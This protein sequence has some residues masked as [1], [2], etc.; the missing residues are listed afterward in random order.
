MFAYLR[1]ISRFD[2]DL[3]IDNGDGKPITEEQNEQ[4]KEVREAVQDEL[5]PLHNDRF[6]TRYL[7]AMNFNVAKA[8]EMV[9]NHLQWRKDMEAERPIDELLD[10]VPE[11][12]K[13]FAPPPTFMGE[14][15]DGFPIAWD[16]PGRIDANGVCKACTVGDVARYHG[17]VFMEQ[18]YDTLRRQS[19]KHN[20]MVDKFIV[21]QDMTNWSMRHMH[22]SLIGMVMETTKV[23]NANYPQILKTMIVINPP[24][25][26]NMCWKLIKPFLRER[27]RK[28]IHFVKGNPKEHL[29]K[30]MSEETIPLMFG[31]TAPDPPFPPSPVP[32]SMYLTSQLPEEMEVV[33]VH[34]GKTH[35]IVKDLMKGDVLS[36]VVHTPHAHDIGIGV[37]MR[38]PAG[39]MTWVAEVEKKNTKNLPDFGTYECTKD[40][41]FVLVFDNTYSYL[42]GKQVHFTT[43][44]THS[45]SQSI[46]GGKHTIGRT[47]P[48]PTTTATTTT[49]TTTTTT[50]SSNTPES[51]QENGRKGSVVGYLAHV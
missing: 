25:I 37:Y 1:E 21:V 42:T 45:D 24:T 15:R 33:S 8:I 26:I 32:E 2:E 50:G 17:F 28:K 9:K 27:T 40:G 13:T 35:E 49:T 34:R 29:L 11:V 23:R 31:G 47:S 7:A 20:K 14:D 48:V 18:V 3:P 38:G 30:I 12:A 19:I 16:F 4:V 10:T 51:K 22:K 39:K 36:W 43:T 6:L 46:D 5:D 41:T 44:V